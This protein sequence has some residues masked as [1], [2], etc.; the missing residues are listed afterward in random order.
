M[1]S[2]CIVGYDTRLF[3]SFCIYVTDTQ[4]AVLSHLDITVI[5]SVMWLLILWCVFH[6]WYTNHHLLLHG[7][8]KILKYKKIKH[9]KNE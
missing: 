3:V 4:S 6:Y 7:L 8:Y 5:F 9:F 2:V 1:V